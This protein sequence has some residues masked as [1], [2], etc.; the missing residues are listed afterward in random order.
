MR[1]NMTKAEALKHFKQNI[2]PSI[3][4]NDRPALRE[5]WLVFTDSLCKSGM[6]SNKQYE[7]WDNPF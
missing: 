4:K 1:Y 7:T 6:I 2:L 5:E 3:P